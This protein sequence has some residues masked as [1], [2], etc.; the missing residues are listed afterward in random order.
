MLR[1]APLVLP[2]LLLASGCG[3]SEAREAVPGAPLVVAS[4]FP[5]GDLAARI[6][7]GAVRVE[8]LLPP[9]ASASTFEPTARQMARL[10]GATAYV[11]VGG[12]MDRW[13]E[14]LVQEGSEVERLTEGMTLRGGHEGEGETGDPHVWLDPVL[15]RDYLLPRIETAVLRAAPDSAAAIRQRTA[16]LADSLTALDG[17]IRRALA[18]LPSRSFVSTHSAWGYFAERYDLREVGSIYESPGREPS[19]RRI[20]QLVEAARAAA[21][22]AVFVEPQLGE[23][24]T[25]AVAAELGLEVHLLDPYGGTSEDGRDRYL[26]LMRFNTRQMVQALGGAS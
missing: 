7:G 17:E 5:L 6:G 25:R 2:L 4:I 22:Q 24:G 10:S 15:V 23:A 14:A 26:S 3:R 12:G 19:S 21:V 13:A 9:R 1:G 11:F 8:V 20:A 16:A 18:G